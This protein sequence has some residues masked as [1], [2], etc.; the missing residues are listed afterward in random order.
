MFNSTYQYSDIS[1]SLPPFHYAF[2]K[3]NKKKI[4]CAIKSIISQTSPL[5]NHG[6]GGMIQQNI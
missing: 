1:Q 4:A 3:G 6:K 5:K 2:S